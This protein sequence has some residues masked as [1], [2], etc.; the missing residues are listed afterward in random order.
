MARRTISS[1]CFA[2]MKSAGGL[3]GGPPVGMK[4]TES[5]PSRARAVSATSRWHRWM[6]LTRRRTARASFPELTGAEHDE[7]GAGEL[8]QAHRA[9]RVDSGRADADVGP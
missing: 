3:W 6:G 7:L 8:L 4:R 9:A 2:G 1:R 5:R